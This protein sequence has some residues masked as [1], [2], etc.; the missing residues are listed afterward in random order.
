MSIE[1]DEAAAA[2]GAAA[3]RAV[4]DGLSDPLLRDRFLAADPV[5]LM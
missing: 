1:P 5:R 4:L 2:D 3:V